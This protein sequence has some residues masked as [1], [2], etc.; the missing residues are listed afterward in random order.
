MF[1]DS[2]WASTSSPHMMVAKYGIATNYRK[3]V[4][5]LDYFQVSKKYVGLEFAWNKLWEQETRLNMDLFGVE[6]K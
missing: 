4:T 1:H 6:E 5:F 3:H 2:S